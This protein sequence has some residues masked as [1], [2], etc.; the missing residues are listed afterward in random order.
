[1]STL[2]IAKPV[3]KVKQVI[4]TIDAKNMIPLM[5]QVFKQYLIC[6][7][8]DPLSNCTGSNDTAKTQYQYAIED[9]V[10]E[11]PE[12]EREII[13]AR[14]MQNEYIKD[15][16]VY[17]LLEIPISKFTYQRRRNSAFNKLFIAFQELGILES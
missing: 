15:W 4:P 3:V 8:L 12:N 2:L 5:E 11:L 6:K 9:V 10:C 17:E 14:Y 13:T 16:Q 7:F 1:M